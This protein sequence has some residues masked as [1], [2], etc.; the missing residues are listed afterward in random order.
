MQPTRQSLNQLTEKKQATEKAQATG[1]KSRGT[2]SK[3]S[4]EKQAEVSRYKTETSACCSSRQQSSCSSFFEDTRNRTEGEHSE[5]ME[6]EVSS[7]GE[8]YSNKEGSKLDELRCSEVHSCCSCCRWSS[9]YKHHYCCG[10]C[11][12]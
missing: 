5:Y 4:P 7:G 1:K 3:F 12:C 10:Y 6:E 11:N 9:Y 8:A 2:Y